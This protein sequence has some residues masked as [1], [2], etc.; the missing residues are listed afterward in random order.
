MTTLEEVCRALSKLRCPPLR[1]EYDLHGLA[2]EAL[3]AAEIA[4]VHEARLAPRCR[5]DFLCGE[6]G[7]ECKRGKVSPRQILAQLNKYAQQPGIAGL[8]LLSEHG[9]AL[10]DRLC[11]KPL[12]QL[13]LNRLWGVALNSEPAERPAERMD[14]QPVYDDSPA[15][16]LIGFAD[17]AP[18]EEAALNDLYPEWQQPEIELPPYLQ[19]SLAVPL[20]FYGTLHYIQRSRTWQIKAEPQVIETL[21]RLWPSTAGGRRG[22]VRRAASRRTAEDLSW[23]MQ[24]WPLEMAPEDRKAWR[25]ALE[26][27]QTA[28]RQRVI[29]S[30]STAPA[31]P[32]PAA[33]EGELKEFQ[34]QGLAFLLATPHALLADEMGLGKTVQALAAIGTLRAVPALLVVPPHLVLNWIRETERFLR[35]QGRPAR[36]HVLKGLTPY[37]LPEADIY[38]VHYL[39]LRGWKQALASMSFRMIVF[40]EIQELRR[41]GSEKYSAAS[42]LS[43]RC[44][45]VVGLS[46]TPIYNHGAE[47]WNVINILEYHF[48]GDYDSFTREWCTGYGNQVVRRPAELGAYLRR[49]GIMLRRTKAEVL[50]ELPEKRRLVQEIDHD[51]RTYQQMMLPVWE[52]LRRLDAPQ[53]SASE[54]A[55]LENEVSQAERQATGLSKAPFVCQFVRAL[56]EAGESVLLFAHHHSVMD[57]YRRELKALRPSFITGRET[58][59]QKE[60]SAARFMDG[61]TDLCCISL[62]AASGLNLQRA[63]CVVFGELDWSPAVHA[64]AEDRAHRIGQRDSLLCYYLVAP[65]G[66]DGM[67]QEALGL[68]VSQFAG[69]M[70]EKLQ[71][72][73]ARQADAAYARKHVE[74]LM[75]RRSAEGYSFKPGR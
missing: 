64:Q 30:R 32:P 61:T 10:P 12:R 62:R 17:P 29:A 69:L 54:R 23:V 34:K 22:E 53:M 20:R 18:E 38:I 46:G 11:G 74:E 19:E 27:A 14:L 25:Q 28:Y 56:V 49:E 66:S 4:F 8:V 71:S 40:D 26:Q 68:K 45:R 21:K 6:I 33:F 73:E 59:P 5:I 9:M 2:A 52:L 63:T 58:A 65:H 39:L 43:E 42:M 37:P 75:K 35:I 70:G 16:E 55:L 67:I 51:D 31:E 24:R 1:D 47:I 3:Q 36:I 48:L 13:S 15:G 44:E 72:E 41:T 50:P 7:I 57:V 60:E